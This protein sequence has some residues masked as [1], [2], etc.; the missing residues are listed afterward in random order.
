MNLG[1][2]SLSSLRQRDIALIVIVLTI[3]LGVAW[4]YYMYRPAGERI[5]ALEIQIDGLNAD[6]LRGET[7]RDNIEALRAELER[8]QVERSAFLAEL[9]RESEVAGLLNQIRIGAQAA[10]V[11]FESI[12]QSGGAGEQIQDVRPIGFSVSTQGE[13]LETMNFLDILESL[14]RFTKIR[15]V[16]LNVEDDGIDS[17]NLNATYDFTVYVYTGEAA[18]DVDEASQ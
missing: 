16:G 3:L 12:N 14:Q 1:N 8:A 15:Q 17:P 6:I 18:N 9:P 11:Q 4:F 5:D 10:E 7:A 2:F 13:Y